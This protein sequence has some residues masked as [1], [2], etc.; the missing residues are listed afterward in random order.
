MLRTYDDG[1]DTIP[2]GIT[3]DVDHVIVVGAGMS[4]LAAAN[5]LANAGVRVTVL[6]GRQRLGGRLHTVD[7]GGSLVDMGGAWIHTP[8][9]NPLSDL[10]EQVGVARRPAH[11][12]E[13][14]VPWDPASGVVDAASME[15]VVGLGEATFDEA[16][17]RLAID[18]A[19]AP[20]S[21]VIDRFIAETDAPDGPGTVGGW[22]RSY[23]RTMAELDA[24]APA[25]QITLRGYRS[26]TLEYE[27]D[28]VGDFP[29]GGYRTL[30]EAL[31]DGLDIRLGAEVASVSAG[32]DGVRVTTTAGEVH[33]GSHV[34]VTVP[35]GVLKAGVI[36]FDPPLGLAH[37]RAIDVIGFGRFEKIAMRFDRPFWTE[38][39][40]P[41]VF[42]LPSDGSIQVP[43]L[44]GIDGFVG[45][46]VVLALTAGSSAGLIGDGPPD[47]ALGRVLDLLEAVTGHR[48]VPV[49]VERT[50]WLADPF[51]RGAYAYPGPHATPDDFLALAGPHAGRVLFS[52]EAT[53]LERLGYA[54][55]AF[56]TGLREAKRLLGTA[57]VEVGPLS[58]RSD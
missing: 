14:A 32:A 52:G 10:A 34:L 23:L 20:F 43:S 5:A 13:H 25:E 38:A 1:T 46:P 3:G 11:I 19:D 12:F 21:E 41:C 55:G 28:P 39:G 57:S 37:A 44:V 58:R 2:G 9:G 27:G 49:A 50:S 45:E 26:A 54:D 31:A 51:A 4:G 36:R 48:E 18:L 15:Q 6:E 56:R 35:L 8:I 40:F 30:I 29:V 16:L 17:E 42:V 24:A 22:L 7:V 33:E 53:T 47:E